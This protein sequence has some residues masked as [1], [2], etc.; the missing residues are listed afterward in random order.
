MY[1]P[2]LKMKKTL[3]SVRTCE[4]IHATVFTF[5]RLLLKVTYTGAIDAASVV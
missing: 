4:D 2:F 3:K 1:V 5:L